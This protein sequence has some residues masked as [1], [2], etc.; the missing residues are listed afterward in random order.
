[1]RYLRVPLITK[2]IYY[3]DCEILVAQITARIDFLTVRNLS[4]ASEIQL[5]SS[6]LFNL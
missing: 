2:R 6:V 3:S 5:L 4:F 1:V